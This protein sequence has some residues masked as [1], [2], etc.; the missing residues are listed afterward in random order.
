MRNIM[1]EIPQK[2]GL[3]AFLQEVRDFEDAGGNPLADRVD[4]WVSALSA[5]EEKSDFGVHFTAHN[6]LKNPDEQPLEN[7]F[8]QYWAWKA[9]TSNDATNKA[10]ETAANIVTA[11]LGHTEQAEDVAKEIRALISNGEGK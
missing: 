9:K 5:N 6:Q 3:I 10:I 11:M 7:L 2:Q 1:N 8:I 4:Q